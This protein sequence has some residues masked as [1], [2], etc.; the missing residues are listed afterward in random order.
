MKLKDFINAMQEI[1]EG[2]KLSKAVVVSALEE[3]LA[4]AF[5]KHI[6]IP[7]ALVRVG[8]EEKSGEIK[9]FQ[10][11]C[12]VETLEDDE[13]EISLEDAR[14]IRQEYQLGDLVEEEV[15]IRSFGRAA[16][17]LAKN[18]MKQKIREAEKLAIYEEYIDKLDDLV[19]GTVETVE[20]KFA[21]VNIGKTIA[22]MPRVAQIP[23]ET[24]REGQTIRVVVSEVNKETKG[25]QVLVSRAD[26]NLVK[27]L[28]EKEVPEIYQGVVEI[29][30]IAREA[31]ERTKMAVYS[32]NENVDPI[33][34]CIGPRGSR[35]Q[36]VIDELAGEKIDI[37]EWSDDVSE[38]IKNA[39]APA[40]VLAVIAHNDR[41]GGL[42]VVVPDNLL[43]LAIGKKGKNARLAV[44]LTGSKIDI[45]SESDVRAMG[46]NFEQI[47][48]EQE[49][50]RNAQKR[51][52]FERAQAAQFDAYE[53]A[54]ESMDS[55]VVEFEEV[56]TLE[57]TTQTTP[58]ADATPIVEEH[59]EVAVEEEKPRELDEYEI[60]AKKAKELAKQ[61]DIKERQSYV[62]KLE[63]LVGAPSSAKPELKPRPKRRFERDDEEENQPRRRVATYDSS[64][65][66]YAMKPIYSEEE[67]AEIEATQAKDV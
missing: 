33:G 25:A 22:L 31:G 62:S 50:A 7:D 59:E 67:L 18:V 30:A 2:R 9:V 26:A 54:V 32:K 40:S 17:I 35:V 47:A 36:V 4:K 5:R 34:A 42:L 60:A 49:Q 65:R 20:E 27:R 14:K 23:G 46:I 28:F 52:A 45:K 21:L 39:L 55:E 44:K 43:S 8:I 56:A 29:K 13:L 37:F 16:V 24:Y 51:A 63:S 12:V 57:E 61:K 41:R 1:E 15:D 3:A 53:D 10:Q 66:D 19:F 11:R 64:K 48:F 38:L 58:V 6:E